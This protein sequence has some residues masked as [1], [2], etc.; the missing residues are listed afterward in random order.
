MWA[1]FPQWAQE[2]LQRKLPLND[3]ACRVE[4]S[5][6]KELGRRHAPTSFAPGFA[7]FLQKEKS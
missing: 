7:A 1:Q 6:D 4:D 5:Q 2:E 3:S